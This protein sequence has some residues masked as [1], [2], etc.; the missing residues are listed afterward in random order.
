M[1]RPGPADHHVRGLLGAEPALL[2]E[3]GHPEPAPPARPAA[4]L[5]LAGVTEPV[6][7]GLGRRQ[8]RRV[9]ARVQ[10][11]IGAQGAHRALAR[12]FPGV[13][14]VARANFVAADF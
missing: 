6:R 10:D 8:Q 14:E 7:F 1:H 4:P 13:K 12:Q 9:V 11:D 3:R 5:H 2:Q